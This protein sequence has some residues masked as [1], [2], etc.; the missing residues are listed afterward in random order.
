MRKIKDIVFG[1]NYIID[2]INK[3]RFNVL[4]VKKKF[5][6]DKLIIHYINTLP[7]DKN[8]LLGVINYDIIRYYRREITHPKCLIT[9]I[10]ETNIRGKSFDYLIFDDFFVSD[11]LKKFIIIAPTMRF[12]TGRI[13]LT[14]TGSVSNEV[15]DYY[16]REYKK[17]KRR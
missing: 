16:L 4:M 3:D 17:I 2:T 1:C 12:N 11:W 14:D 13:L 15:L 7:H 6:L 5:R 9:T 10:L 8:V